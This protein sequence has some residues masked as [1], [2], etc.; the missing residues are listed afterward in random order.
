MG[1]RAFG[2]QPPLM[3]F[4]RIMTGIDLRAATTET[5]IPACPERPMIPHRLGAGGGA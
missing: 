2:P 1:G 4:L 5:L 3:A